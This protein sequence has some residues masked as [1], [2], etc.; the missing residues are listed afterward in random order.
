MAK[1]GYG[2][3]A[4]STASVRT[5]VRAGGSGMSREPRNYK[6]DWAK[7]NEKAPE[8]WGACGSKAK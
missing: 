4:E 2:T 7:I 3:S 5:R 8:D 1:K 6:N